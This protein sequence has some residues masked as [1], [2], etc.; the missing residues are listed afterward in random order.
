MT[1]DVFVVVI[2]WMLIGASPPTS[3]EPTLP[4]TR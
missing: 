4:L 1:S 3:T 2:D